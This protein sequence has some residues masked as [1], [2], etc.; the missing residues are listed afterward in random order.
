M[1]KT[2]LKALPESELA[3]YQTLQSGNNC[4]LHAISAVLNLLCGLT[5]LPS[6]LVE[7]VNRLWWHGHFY[8]ILPNY[9]V[10]PPMQARFVNYL[11]KTRHLPV[12]ARLLHTSSEILRNLPNDEDI[13][14]MVTLYW[15]PGQ[16][17]AIYHGFRGVNYNQAKGMGG[18]T[19]LFASYDPDHL[20]DG[21]TP[22]PWGFINS[23]AEGSTNLFWMEDQSFRKSWNFP[24]PRLGRNPTVLIS[25]SNLKS[26]AA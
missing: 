16:A 1:K 22:T 23:W 8:R 10:T 25:M 11:S 4:T 7:E 21:T 18:H 3:R 12:S 5:I 9:A 20:T 14:A 13:A 6:E 17:P 26:L 24:L 2:S 19:M 15:L